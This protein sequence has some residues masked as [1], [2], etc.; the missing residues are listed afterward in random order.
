MKTLRQINEE[1]DK[2]V[3]GFFCAIDEELVKKIKIFIH[4]QISLSEQSLLERVEKEMPKEK[5]DDG[6]VHDPS[7]AFNNGFDECLSEIKDLLTSLKY[8]PQEEVKNK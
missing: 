8:L 6:F 4:T 3:E 1:F 7:V 5:D 2:E